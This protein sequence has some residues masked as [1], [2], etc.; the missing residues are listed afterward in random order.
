MSEH[1][2]DGGWVGWTGRSRAERA[3]IAVALGFKVVLLLLIFR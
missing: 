1:G 3:F 2:W